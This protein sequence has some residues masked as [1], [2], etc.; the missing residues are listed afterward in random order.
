MRKTGSRYFSIWILLGAACL[1]VL[2]QNAAAQ[3]FSVEANLSEN[4]V[5]IGEQF[6]LSIVVHGTTSPDIERPFLPDLHGVRNVTPSPSRSQTISI[7]NGQT[8]RTTSYTYTL[9]AQREGRFQIPSIRVTVDGEEYL[10]SPVQL[11]VVSRQA[12]DGASGQNYPD[13]FARI[14]LDEEKPI[15]GQQLIASLVIYFKEGVEVSS[16]Q[17]RAGWRTDGFWKEQLENIEQ[18][19]A[20]S[21]ILG[22]TRYRKATLLRYALF[23][24]RAGELTLTPFELHLSIRTSPRRND[25][26]GSVFGALGTNQRRVTIQTDEITLPVERIDEPDDVMTIGAVGQFEIQRETNLRQAYAGESIELKTTIEGEGNLPLL[27]RPR[28]PI[29]DQFELYTPHD[30]SD[31]SRR[32]TTIHGKRTFTERFAARTPGTFTIPEQS[33]AWYDPATQRFR[34][35]NLPEITFE[36]L[37]NPAS[38]LADAETDGALQMITSTATWR[39]D[40]ENSPIFFAAWWY[41][42]FT[43]LPLAALIYAWK[44]K[45]LLDRLEMDRQFARSHR[46]WDQ[47]E[48]RLI[49]AESA[50][51]DQPKGAYSLL[52]KAITGYISDRLALPEAG[53][54]D[55]HLLVHLED[56]IGNKKLAGELRLMLDK[57]ANISY[58][59]SQN[60]QETEQDIEKTRDLLRRLRD[61]L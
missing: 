45:R 4:Q 39:Y 31:I 5:F 9:I 15:V 21:T 12:G 42:I 26:F 19:R 48:E 37:P 34:Y 46:A 29:P 59:P 13:I 35:E 44:Q 20:E 10:T 38:A 47:V 57:C 23:P 49:N 25:P 11:E 51:G 56:K 58:A 2:T 17:P 3:N 16:F 40:S 14:E 7:V 43:L 30:Q 41:W 36:I 8:T 27:E 33:V 55:H 6:T 32:G 24:S 1:A 61:A 52:H 18:P 28:Y 60:R 22:G 54:S 53:I 50:A